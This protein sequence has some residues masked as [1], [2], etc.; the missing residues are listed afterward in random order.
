MP[1]QHATSPVGPTCGAKML[2]WH[3]V[4]WCGVTSTLTLPRS[5]ISGHIV[6]VCVSSRKLNSLYCLS[7]GAQPNFDIPLPLIN[8][9]SVDDHKFEVSI[10]ESVPSVDIKNSKTLVTQEIASYLV[11]ENNFDDHKLKAKIMS[12]FWVKFSSTFLNLE[13]MQNPIKLLIERQ[14]WHVNDIG[15]PHPTYFHLHADEDFISW[16]FK[17]I[18]SSRNNLVSFAGGARPHSPDSIR[19]VLIN[20][21]TLSGQPR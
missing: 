1:H 8:A 16:K 15:I 4:S 11:Q 21:C 20:Q 2:T 9:S 14:P 6:H 3:D 17:I 5:I 10:R 7:S 19:S 18:Q 12:L 13:E